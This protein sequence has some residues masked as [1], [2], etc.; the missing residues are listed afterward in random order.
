MGVVA[1]WQIRELPGLYQRGEGAEFINISYW[2]ISIF[3]AVCMMFGAIQLL[4]RMT[5][6]A[7][8]AIRNGAEA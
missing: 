1:I 7:R 2:P 8:D 4:V 3:V 6:R 5:E